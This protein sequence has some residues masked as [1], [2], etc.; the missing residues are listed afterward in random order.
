MIPSLSHQS[1]KPQIEYLFLPRFILLPN[2]TF[3][4]LFSYE[5]FHY[6]L[7][8]GKKLHMSSECNIRDDSKLRLTPTAR[9]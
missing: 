5:A 8:Y 6:Q 4:S 3:D 1:G 2:I 7:E 9:L